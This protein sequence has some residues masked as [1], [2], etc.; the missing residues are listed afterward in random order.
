M[1]DNLANRGSETVYFIL[2]FCLITITIY[3]WLLKIFIL[4]YKNHLFQEN[5]QKCV[6]LMYSYS[7]N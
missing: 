4:L 6:Y 2:E 3:K 1:F 7:N 5:I